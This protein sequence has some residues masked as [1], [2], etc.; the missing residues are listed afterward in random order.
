MIKQQCKS[1]VL[2]FFLILSAAL[3]QA[4]GLIVVGRDDGMTVAGAT[5]LS[6]TG[7][8]LG[9]T[10]KNGA[11]TLPDNAVYPLAVRSMGYEVA[12]VAAPRDTVVLNVMDYALPEVSVTATERP[13]RRVVWY[14]REYSTGTV[15]SDTMQLYSEYMFESFH[16]DRKVKGYHSSDALLSTKAIKRYARIS[17]ANRCDSVFRPRESDDI[18][19]LAWGGA[20]CKLPGGRTEETQAIRE[21]APA[22][23]IAGKYGTD[24]IY[25]KGDN[26]YMVIADIL[27]S[28]KEHRWSPSIF[29]LF[30]MT[31]DIGRYESM[32]CFR[33]NE[34]GVYELYDLMYS[35]VNLEVLARGKVFKWI[36]K[37][38]EPI[39]MNTCIELYPVEI[40]S[41]SLTEYKEMRKDKALLE[42]RQ[43]ES[44]LPEIPAVTEIKQLV[45]TAKK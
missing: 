3:S 6:A 22:D 33:Q 1:A 41:H 37:S 2:A 45:A 36:L 21:G 43:P 30:G 23:S 38:K 15:G 44:V 10:D 20:F 40:T 11:V 28:H 42:F 16:V 18:T 17:G 5:L 34:H 7:H 9:I 24:K 13:F 12:T 4:K 27:S 8:I 25:L 26:R 19:T 39:K 29:K 35:S 32:L 31:I 14:A